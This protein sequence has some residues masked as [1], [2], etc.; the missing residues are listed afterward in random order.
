MIAPREIVIEWFEER[1]VVMQ[2]PRLM[3]PFQPTIFS[4]S[5]HAVVANLSVKRSQA[6]SISSSKE[7][8]WSLLRSI[9]RSNVGI[10][11]PC[12]RLE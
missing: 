1:G 12:I 4:T 3:P 10:L 6:R 2:T 7:K 9:K 11:S 8:V 5:K